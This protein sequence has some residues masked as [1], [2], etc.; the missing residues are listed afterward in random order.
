MKSTNF[1]KLKKETGEG[2]VEMKDVYEAFNKDVKGFLK[3]MNEDI[4]L[5]NPINSEEG[6]NEVFKKLNSLLSDENKF[7]NEY[8]KNKYET[9]IVKNLKFKP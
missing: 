6:K 4:D 8:N 2:T 3:T 1:D 5:E 7:I 9:Q